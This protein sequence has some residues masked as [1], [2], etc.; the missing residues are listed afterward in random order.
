[1]A[2]LVAAAAAAVCAAP[3]CAAGGRDAGAVL[4][5]LHTVLQTTRNYG[6][7]RW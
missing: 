3:S 7:I 6:V 5:P 1:M 4:E 2:A